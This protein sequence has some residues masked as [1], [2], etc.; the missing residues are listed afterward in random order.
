M[1][2]RLLGGELREARRD[3][4][5]AAFVD[6]AMR[7]VRVGNPVQHVKLRGAGKQCLARQHFPHH[8]ADAPDIDAVRVVFASQNLDG[9]VPQ[10]HHSGR[11]CML[12]FVQHIAG[13]PK[14][15]ELQVAT[16]SHEQVFGLHISMHN[17]L[18]MAM[19]EC[20]QKVARV[21]AR[22]IH[23]DWAAHQLSQRNGMVLH[24]Y[25]Q[26]VA[27]TFDAD[28]RDDVP[29][30][31][32]R[33]HSNLPKRGDGHTC[34]RLRLGDDFRRY[35]FTIELCHANDAVRSSAHLHAPNFE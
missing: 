1:F 27:V 15:G 22:N 17:A 25:V 6:Q 19:G 11:V 29:V 23:H 31:Q 20:E 14:I 2:E 30:R 35:E 5:L 4:L 28:E 10:R 16:A 8:T 3:K 12:R 24:L 7:Q 9:S 32:P 13:Q 26:A 33:Q 18:G 34:P 21:S